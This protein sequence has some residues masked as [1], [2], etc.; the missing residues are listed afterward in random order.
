MGGTVTFAMRRGTGD[1]GKGD[2]VGGKS[3]KAREES[4]RRNGRRRGLHRKGKSRWTRKS[5]P[6]SRARIRAHNVGEGAVIPERESRG[7]TAG[8]GDRDFFPGLE[9]QS[10]GQSDDAVI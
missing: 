5:A 8:C 10:D 2:K 6:L 9:V 4:T 7:L 1:D 3:R